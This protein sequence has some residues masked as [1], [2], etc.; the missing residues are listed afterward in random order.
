MCPPAN[1]R[2]Q[3]V[4]PETELPMPTSRPRHNPIGPAAAVLLV[5]ACVAL[6]IQCLPSADEQASQRPEKP[7]AAEH[8]RAAE[9]LQPIPTTS[10]R[11]TVIAPSRPHRLPPPV[12]PATPAVEA[13][14]LLELLPP[15]PPEDLA[16]DQGES[17]EPL[18]VVVEPQPEP[19]EQQ[20]LQADAPPTTIKL[21]EPRPAAVV[22]V[23]PS[24]GFEAA[25]FDEDAQIVAETSVD[26]L[27]AYFPAENELS[28]QFRPRVQQTY[29]LARHGA[30]HAARARFEQ[31]LLELAQAKDASQ[32]TSRHTR[33]LAAGLR[34][35]E[36]AD[37]FLLRD[38]TTTT[39][40]KIA[41]GHQT[42]MLHEQAEWT[43]PH[44]AVAMY[45]LYAQQKLALAVEGEQAGSM[46]L[47]GLGKIYSQLSQRD[48]Q[49][50]AVRKSLTMYRSAVGAH[51]GNHLAANE[52][53]VL[54]ARAGRYEQAVGMLERASQLADSSVTHRNL[55][56]VMAK[57]DR[58]QQAESHRARAEQI[59]Q[60][61]IA[62]G[63]LSAERGITWVS[64]DE[65]ARRGAG[66]SA[67][68]V[69]SRP[70]QPTHQTPPTAAPPATA[71]RPT[72]QSPT[73]PMW[74]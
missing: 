5:T 42:P 44:E 31:L 32:M 33:A 13:A 12:E 14:P 55:S 58:P 53:G 70:V 72:S 39:P 24:R 34:A 56:Y 41:A 73:H 64:P 50:Q 7:P 16:G 21:T 18:P 48:Q 71:A 62:H 51:A 59:A 4:A 27:L 60:L 22:A 26:D 1:T 49:P 36:E 15:I 28:K 67:A 52:A 29:T 30:L 17:F 19:A 63:Q 40:Q 3:M 35:I 38:T 2:C 20:L 69:A 66:D 46:M 43:L 74:W 47:F 8:P 54:L 61:E 45:H 10:V 23:T 11:H 65:F 57:L 6:G 25:E 68:A 37:E 9:Q